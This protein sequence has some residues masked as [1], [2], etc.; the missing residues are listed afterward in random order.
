MISVTILTK[1]SANY[2]EQVLAALVSFDEV[3]I[4]DTGSTDNTLL[5][6]KKFPNVTIREGI[7]EGFGP[8]HNKASAAAK[9]DWILSIDSDEIVTPELQQ[10]I[11]GLKLDPSKVYS[12]RRNNYYNGKWI[13]WCGW[14]P[15]RQYR[16]YNRHRTQFDDA[17]VHES[18]M[19][20][21]MQRTPLQNA[22]IHYPYSSTA[23]FLQKM[24]K[25]TELFAEQNKGKKSSSTG[26]AIKHALY[27]FFKSY[28]LKKGFLGGAEGFTIAVYNANT[29]FYKY[30][31]LAEKNK[32][33]QN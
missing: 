8:T 33:K 13:K 6:A 28:L 16:L 15:D 9:H 24:Q 11:L 21:D 27:A 17:Q 22:L 14:Y 23:D 20:A 5:I 12:I 4:Y 25:Y 19:L 10:E 29:A 31:K 2:L 7:L 18:I 3:L 1:N 32:N 30:L 26:K